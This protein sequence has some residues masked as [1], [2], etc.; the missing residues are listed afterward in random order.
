MRC[1]LSVLILASFGQAAQAQTASLVTAHAHGLAT[2]PSAVE[3]RHE[4]KPALLDLSTR[5][6][7]R[8]ILRR[9]ATL[10]GLPA[11]VA[12]AVTQIE[13]SYNPAAIGSVGEIGLMQ[14]RPST[15]AMLGFRGTIAELA[16][17]E[18]NIRYGVR[19]LA[20]AWRLS[21]GDLCRALMKYRAGHGSETMSPLS[22]AYCAR[23]QAVLKI[24]GAL[25]VS[26]VVP[27]PVPR[28][29]LTSLTRTE[30]PKGLKRG[31]PE[32]EKAYWSAHEARIARLRAQ[33]QASWR[34]RGAGAT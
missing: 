19:Y 22:A 7:Y 14:V 5:A 25:S 28:S 27:R 34:A 33:V 20:E 6:A 30:L 29:R 12:E 32:F 18:V 15:A 1:S 8:A 17:P 31:T 9:E 2:F 21:N 13:S 4:A 23:A 24:P 16:Q 11:E 26:Q 3:L 10:A